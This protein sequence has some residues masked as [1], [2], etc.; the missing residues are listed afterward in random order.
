MKKR[1]TWLLVATILAT[2]YTI[3]LILYFSDAISGT[4]GAEQAGSVVATALVTPHIIMFAVGAIFGWIGYCARKA[5]SALVAAI[6]Y[7]VGTLFFLVYAMFGVPILIFG[8]IGFAN[9]RK[10]NRWH[11]SNDNN[12]DYNYNVE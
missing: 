12:N 10:I 8:F 6:L 4:T 7:S 9:Q 2:A 1:S 11:P 5:W 3:Y